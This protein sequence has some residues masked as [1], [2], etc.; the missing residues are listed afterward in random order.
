[1]IS[2]N[3]GLPALLLLAAMLFGAGCGGGDG[4]ASAGA[5]NDQ[6]PPVVTE[7]PPPTPTPTPNAVPGDRLPAP[8]TVG[9][10]PARL[11]LGS[12]ATNKFATGTVR[13]V[14]NG[15]DP[16]TIS[17][18]KSSCGCTSTN[19]PK[20][21]E[22]KPGE[23]T[24][25]EIRVTGGAR[26]RTINKTVTFRVV[27]QQPVILPV[28]V[29][30]IAYVITVPETIDPDQ[31]PEGGIIIKSTDEQ[32]FRITRMSP[33]ILKDFPAEAGVEHTVN[34]D[35]EVWRDLG[36]TRRL[37]FT[38][39]HPQTDTASVTVRIRPQ[40]ADLPGDPGGGQPPRRTDAEIKAAIAVK[41]GNA[42]DLRD[43]LAVGLTE[44]VRNEL[45]NLAARNGQV[46]IMGVLVEAGASATAMDSRGRT[47]LMSAV[48]SKNP[49]AL[50][51]LIEKGADVN[52][53]DQ[54]Q[55]TALLR[56]AG[57]FGDIAT[58]Q[59]LLSAGAEVNV[60]DKN[61]MTP[62]MWAARWGD[63]PRVEALVEAGGKVDARDTNGRTA[64]DWA[65]SR[66]G[67]TADQTIE[68]LQRLTP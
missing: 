55:S 48:Q 13:L 43:Q 56:A 45:L 47:P 28:S 3:R 60:R 62:L 51:L 37:V 8:S 12:V 1:M 59:V 65:R 21:Q 38:V 4:S 40:R 11:D 22:L 6:G 10:E 57:A 14:N 50:R 25:V 64:L 52:A 16:V 5:Q 34:I 9:V 35:W 39:D 27:D 63:T 67:G 2:A 61:G 53:R 66:A 46:E 26:A 42:D 15:A 18:C 58:V 41:D 54:L 20:G 19:C 32:P 7:P 31:V 24:D 36:Q 23:T 44:A 49:E 33:P 29:E 68:L 17:D 30:V